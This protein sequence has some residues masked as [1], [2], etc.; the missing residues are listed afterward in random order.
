MTVWGVFPSGVEIIAYADDILLDTIGRDG[1]FIK[2]NLETACRALNMLTSTLDKTDMI[3]F[4]NNHS[5]PVDF[6]LDVRGYTVRLRENIRYLEVQ[7]DRK[8]NWMKH[9]SDQC[10][11]AKQFIYQTTWGISGKNCKRSYRAPPLYLELL[12]WAYGAK[13]FA[14]NTVSF[15]P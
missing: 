2:S 4:S 5:I 10:V 12:T 14:S 7:R 9:I 3:L 13:I 15:I 1:I 11:I 8:L 6:P